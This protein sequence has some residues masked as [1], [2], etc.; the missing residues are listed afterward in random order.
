M[1]GERRVLLAGTGEALGAAET[2]LA[3]ARAQLFARVA[4]DGR[5]A[6]ERFADE[7]M[8]AHSFAWMAS[9]VTALRQLQV[10]AVRLDESGLLG[11]VEGLILKIAFGEYLAQL[12][13]GIPMA[14]TEFAR[15]QDLGLGEN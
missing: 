3:A 9:S 2:Y 15:P 11:E 14:Q 5:L 7:Q 13:G 8:A 4:P 6:P 12:A 1:S 10:W